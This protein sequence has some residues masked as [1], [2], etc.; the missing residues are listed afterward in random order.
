MDRKAT[1]AQMRGQDWNGFVPKSIRTQ[2]ALDL[3]PLDSKQLNK[4]AET[5][6]SRE[7]FHN[8]NVIMGRQGDWGKC[9]CE[10]RIVTGRKCLDHLRKGNY[11]PPKQGEK[12][13]N[14]HWAWYIDPAPRGFLCPLV[15]NAPNLMGGGKTPKHLQTCEILIKAP[16][17]SWVLEQ[18]P[19]ALDGA[20]AGRAVTDILHPEECEGCRGTQMHD[21]NR[22]D[23]DQ[24]RKMDFNLQFPNMPVKKP[25]QYM[26][27]GE[28]KHGTL[29]K[30]HYY[31]Y[32]DLHRT[33]GVPDADVYKEGNFKRKEEGVTMDK[34]LRSRR[35]GRK[36]ERLS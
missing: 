27:C 7:D 31:H 15:R 36:R 17:E 19:N 2:L 6:R 10:V 11:A 33:Y 26:P 16:P 23:F 30:W 14:K 18:H 3:I 13:K 21:N 35:T 32:H 9:L 20:L 22:L 24:W 29:T 12:P 34:W 25:M 8:Y 1:G 28:S 5:A 4:F